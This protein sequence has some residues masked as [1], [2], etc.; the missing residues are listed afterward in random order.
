MK[1]TTILLLFFSI[2]SFHFSCGPNE[3]E[4]NTIEK[5]IAKNEQ[6]A[7]SNKD[8]KEQAKQATTKKSGPAFGIDISQF[9]G[10]E[11]SF[12]N[13]KTDELAFV[14]CKATEGITYTDPDFARN[15]KTIGEK[16]FIRGAYHFYRSKDDPTKQAEHF[17]HAINDLKKKNLPP[18]VD[19][20]GAG[21]DKSQSVEVVQKGL[22]Q[23]LV[24][25]EKDL[26][27]VP[28]IYV[29]RPIGN[30]YLNDPVFSKYPL[31]IADYTK[32][33]KPNLPATWAKEGWTF[34]QKSSSHLI[35]AK[36]NDFDQFN[37]D[38]S[39]LLDFTNGG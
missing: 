30:K 5:T 35:D 11:I 21:I 15:W 38:F 22:L 29:D 2:I 31:W 26:D 25:V 20:E 1:A 13:S 10:D 34:W 23:F 32:N 3:Q 12:L 33:E 8:K 4:Q 16:G 9:Q 37:G 17:I 27:R 39:K 14:I 6:S 19:F 18:I 28:I 36:K 24:L 7:I